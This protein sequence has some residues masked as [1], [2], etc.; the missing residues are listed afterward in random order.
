MHNHSRVQVRRVALHACVATAVAFSTIA[1]A[2]EIRPAQLQALAAQNAGVRAFEN[3][4]LEEAVANFEQAYRLSSE[5]D[6]LYQIGEAQYWLRRFDFAK[7]CLFEFLKNNPKS[8]L[9]ER[10]FELLTRIDAAT[11][12]AAA[13]VVCVGPPE[14]PSEAKADAAKAKPALPPMPPPPPP[15]R[16]AI[17]EARPFY[18]TWWFWTAVGVVA[19]GSGAAIAVA[20]SGGGPPSTHL[21]TVPVFP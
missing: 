1:A 10:A 3:G 16:A 15:Q 11:G 5:P 9:A 17:S 19:A 12:G 2:A 8:A 13:T 4:R 21:G 7:S 14:K 18:K 20:A 6:L